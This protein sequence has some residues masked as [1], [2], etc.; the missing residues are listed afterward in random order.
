LEPGELDQP[1]T[2]NRFDS[3]LGNYTVRYF[4][5]TLAGCFGETLARYRPELDRL[6]EIADEWRDLGFMPLGELPAD[7]RHR[8]LAVHVQVENPR[9]PGPARFLDVEHIDTRERLRVEQAQTLSLLGVTDLDVA[10][11]R[12]GDRR[13]TRA[14]S[15]WAHQYRD[16]DGYVFAGVRYLSRLNNDWE[17]WAVFDDVDILELNRQPILREDPALLSVANHYGIRVF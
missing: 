15:W 1:K 6:S 17:C 7:W 4:S 16:D 2:G 11:V 10:T 3:P 5:T 14:I 8:R 9:Y 13:I 12:G